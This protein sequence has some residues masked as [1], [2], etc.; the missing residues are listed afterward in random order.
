LVEER[1]PEV[2]DDGSP[3]AEAPKKKPVLA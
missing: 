2:L 1:L 3:A